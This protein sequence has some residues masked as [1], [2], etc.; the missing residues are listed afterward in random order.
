MSISANTKQT[1]RAA[2]VALAKSSMDSP[3][4]DAPGPDVEHFE[5]RHLIAANLAYANKCAVDIDSD[6]RTIAGLLSLPIHQL[7]YLA[8]LTGEPKWRVHADALNE[9]KL[10]LLDQWSATVATTK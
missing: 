1:L 6:P 4:G 10:A 3:V 9:Q 7:A 2:I 8:G 5:L